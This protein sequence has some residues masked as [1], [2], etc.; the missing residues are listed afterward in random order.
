M[1]L[2]SPDGQDV[3]EIFFLLVTAFLVLAA[4]NG[5]KRVVP[6]DRLPKPEYVMNTTRP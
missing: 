4:I 6:L 1:K 3:R 5:L 2:P